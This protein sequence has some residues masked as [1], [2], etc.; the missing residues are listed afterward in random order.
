[1]S[2]ILNPKLSFIKSTREYTL[3]YIF[4]VENVYSFINLIKL[5]KI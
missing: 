3:Q 2:N 5:V 1:M 4:F